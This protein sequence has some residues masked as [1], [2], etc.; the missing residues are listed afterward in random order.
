MDMT[1]LE[2]RILETIKELRQQYN[3]CTA[4]AVANKM[5]MNPDSMRYRVNDLRKKGLV[6]WNPMPGS[7]TTTDSDLR[8]QQF[9]AAMLQ[10]GHIDEVQKAI[11]EIYLAKETVKEPAKPAKKPRKARAKKS[12]SA[13]PKTTDAPADPITDDVPTVTE[14]TEP[15]ISTQQSQS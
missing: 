9:I 2:Q 1:N 12:A 5:R 15:E 10:L 11:D 14:E 4:R 6:E 3:A 7:L 8:D 13:P